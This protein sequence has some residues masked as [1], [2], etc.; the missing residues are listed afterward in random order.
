[1]LEDQELEAVEFKKYLLHYDKA[2]DLIIECHNNHVTFKKF[3]GRETARQLRNSIR[4]LINIQRK[5][6]LSVWLSFQENLEISKS[7][8]RISRESKLKHKLE[9]AKL[10]NNS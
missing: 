1:M 4:D 8:K 3:K 6:R 10:K 2:L 7:R 5:L 9:K